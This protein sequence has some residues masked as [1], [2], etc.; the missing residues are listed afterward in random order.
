M[1]VLRKY[2][3]MVVPVRSRKPR[4]CRHRK[5]HFSTPG[6]SIPMPLQYHGTAPKRATSDPFLYHDARLSLVL[7]MPKHNKRVAEG[8]FHNQVWEFF[9][10]A[11]NVSQH[12]S[13]IV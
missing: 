13:H 8:A 10:V 12:P 6:R 9:M 4:D 1:E 3:G 5:Y 2:F 11:P 7:G